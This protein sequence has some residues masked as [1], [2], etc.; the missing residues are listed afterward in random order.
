[1]QGT[2]YDEYNDDIPNGFDIHLSGSFV[3]GVLASVIIF[4]TGVFG[5]RQVRLIHVY[6]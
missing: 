4:Y 3:T 2:N 1:M 5:L 6:A